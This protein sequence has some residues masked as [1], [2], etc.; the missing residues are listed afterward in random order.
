MFTRKVFS[1]S[2]SLLD[3]IESW[4]SV[5][6]AVRTLHWMGGSRRIPALEMSMSRCGSRLEISCARAW[7]E[8][9]EERSHGNLQS[10]N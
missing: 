9:L 4:S 8:D 10:G 6:D 5:I 3:H 7:M 2:A 1:Q